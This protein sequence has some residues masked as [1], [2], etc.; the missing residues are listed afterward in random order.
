M[1]RLNK[2]DLDELLSDNSNIAIIFYRNCLNETF[3]RF[4]N[5]VANFTFSQHNL[6]EKSAILEEINKDLSHAKKIQRYFIDSE[7]IDSEYEHIH[8]KNIN[9][10]YLYHP[11][12]EIGGDFMNI[13]RLDNDHIC[14]IIADVEGH[15]I[16]A[17]LVTGVLKS[18]F[19]IVVDK[20]G[21]KPSELMEFLNRHFVGVISQLYATCYYALINTSERKVILAKAGHHHPFY[22]KKKENDFIPIDS[23]GTGLGLMSNATFRTNEIKIDKGDKM[24]FF[25]DGIIEQ[26]NRNKEMYSKARLKAIFKNCILNNK[27]EIINS[28]AGDLHEFSEGTPYEDDITMVLLEFL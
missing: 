17:A 3:S 15:G 4:R 23:T 16:S 5:I 10:S 8:Q 28:I 9:Y 21:K 26:M 24:L 18:A 11:C 13:S 27:S 2:E 7:Q 12:S 25:T 20:L 19:S 6:K 22:W 1:F 14:M